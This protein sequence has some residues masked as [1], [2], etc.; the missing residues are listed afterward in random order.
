MKPIEY[1]PAIVTKNRICAI[2]AQSDSVR[3]ALN[4]KGIDAK[5]DYNPED[6]LSL[7]WNCIVPALKD[8]DTI[9]TADPQ[10]LV[11]IRTQD[12]ENDPRTVWC[13]VTVVVVINYSD[14]RSDYQYRREDLMYEGI[15]DASK[16]DAIAHYIVEALAS[17]ESKSWI[18][19]IKLVDRDEGSLNNSM[20]YAVTL[21]FEV[22][23]I[24]I[25]NRGV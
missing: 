19:D 6:P 13:L 7:V 22:R 2:I 11:G 16:P 12:N 21:Q 8:P 4:Y 15:S 25:G 9:T 18:G 1:D 5:Y 14:L 20:H 3:A 10:I 17:D 24:N 23:D